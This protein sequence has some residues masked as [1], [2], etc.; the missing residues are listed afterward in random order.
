MMG[1]AEISNARM[2]L[3]APGLMGHKKE[4]MTRSQKPGLLVGTKL[5]QRLP[6]SWYHRKRVQSSEAENDPGD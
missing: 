5:G 3:P 6:T 4:M 1:N 2:F